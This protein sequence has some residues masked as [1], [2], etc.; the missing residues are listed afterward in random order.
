MAEEAKQVNWLWEGRDH[1][2]QRMRGRLAATTLGLARAELRRQGIAPSR[3][4]RERAPRGKRI[5]AAD[6]AYV[7]RQLATMLNA[8]VPIAQAF[9]IIGQGHENQR[10]RRLAY[11]IRTDIES[12]SALSQAL[13]KHP[14]YFDHL[15]VSLVTTG[16]QSGQ[17]DE[18]LQRIATY[19]EKSEELKRKI[20]KA[21]FYPAAVVCAAILVTGVLLIFVIPKFQSF[22]ASFGAT[23]PAFTRW[24]IDFS[25]SVQ[26][27]GWIYLLVFI[28]VIAAI[29]QARKRSARFRRGFD[30]LMLKVPVIGLIMAKSSIARFARTL[31]ITFAAG[32][33]VTEALTTVAQSTGNVIYED[34]VMRASTRVAGGERLYR[35]LEETVLFPNIVTQMIAIGE[36]AGSVDEMAAKVADFYESEVDTLVDGLSTLLEPVIMVVLGIIVGALVVAM[37]LPIFNLGN[38][39]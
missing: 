29:V 39:V 30:R 28:G 5:K 19:K 17:L 36:E 24:V 15:Y 25:H 8:G 32:V 13:A 16:E 7:S 35:S 20:K 11:E 21:L 38:V 12:G 9:G 34:A 37:Y 10:M 27:Y 6:I 31:S 33:P 26:T 1:R 18:I 14:Q 2:G 22:Y 4:R 23:L 3:L